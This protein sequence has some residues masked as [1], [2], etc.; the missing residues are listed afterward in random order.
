MGFFSNPNGYLVSSTIYY[1]TWYLMQNFV[2]DLETLPRKKLNVRFSFKE[3]SRKLIS[4][5]M[6]R[7]RSVAL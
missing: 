1:S 7:N 4:N 6:N 5:E 2:T 3:I